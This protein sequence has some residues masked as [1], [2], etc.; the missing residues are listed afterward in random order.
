[1]KNGSI[2]SNNTTGGCPSANA[3]T[4]VDLKLMEDRGRS[5]S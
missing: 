2:C 3:R 5:A 1:L 4:G